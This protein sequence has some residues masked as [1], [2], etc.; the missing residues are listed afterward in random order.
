MEGP[1]FHFDRCF[2]FYVL[3]VLQVSMLYGSWYVVLNK[4]NNP[5]F[6]VVDVFQ[7][8]MLYGSW[9]VVLNQGNNPRCML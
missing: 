7:V 1:L 8:S 4:G 3:D 9:Y 6:Y 2:Y 5:N